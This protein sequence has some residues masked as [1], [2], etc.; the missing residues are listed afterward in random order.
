M[1]RITLFVVTHC[2]AY[3]GASAIAVFTTR[4]AA[5]ALMAQIDALPSV[6]EYG[7]VSELV[8]NEEPQL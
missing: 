2:Y 1:D 3:E 7:V 5:N 4:E 6:D 8:L